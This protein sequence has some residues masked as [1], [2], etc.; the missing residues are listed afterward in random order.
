MCTFFK[1]AQCDDVRFFA[2][3]CDTYLTDHYNPLSKMG[4][5][6]AIGAKRKE[7]KDIFGKLAKNQVASFVAGCLRQ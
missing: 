6:I 3:F 4:I 1:V 5:L 2:V 7:K